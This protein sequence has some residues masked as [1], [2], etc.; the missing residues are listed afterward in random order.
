M[1]EKELVLGVIHE[2]NMNET[3]YS[4]EGDKAYMNKKVISV[5]K[6][7]LLKDSLVATGFPYTDY[8]RMKEY[9]GVF[10]ELM[11]K[12]HGVRRLGSAAVDLAYVACGRF[13]LFYE[14][15]LQ[16]WDVAAGAFLIKQAGGQ[17]T[18]FKGGN[19]YV[20]G[21]EIITANRHIHQEFLTLLLQHF[22]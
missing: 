16:P 6:K 9:M 11:H 22:K 12:S 7:S 15:G 5:S 4:C 19:D 10:N 18:D 13:E 14:Y 20:F 3:F 21:E 2:P 17:V 8:S 1:R